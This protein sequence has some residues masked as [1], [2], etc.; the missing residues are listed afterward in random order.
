MSG[1]YIHIPF[2]ASFCLYCDFYSEQKKEEKDLYV[3]ALKREIALRKDFLVDSPTTLYFGGG[4]PS[5]MPL[6]SL[7]EILE[8]IKKYYPNGFEEVTIEVNPDDI[9]KEYLLGLKSLGFN[10]I[11]MGVQSFN[12]SHLRWMRRRHNAE[13]AKE[14]FFLM[15]ECGFTNISLDLIFGYSSLTIEDWNNDLKTITTLSPEH[16]SA[17][18]MTLE[19][20]SDLAKTNYSELSSDICA[21]QYS[22][23]QNSLCDSGYAQYEISNFSKGEKYTSKH[24]S[25]YWKREP[26]LGLGP[27]AHSFS[28]RGDCE[29]RS[30]NL[31]DL[32]LY[33]KA[34]NESKREL[35]SSEEE[36]STEEIVEEMVMLG[37][38]RSSGIE[39]TELPQG[40]LESNH[41][42]TALKRAIDRGLIIKEKDNIRIPFDKLFISD[43]IILELL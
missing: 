11:S 38:R 1:I 34:M 35:C 29:I 43:Y 37:L 41:F 40:Y 22:L 39:L 9:S 42:R 31:P 5:T 20:G 6:N 2:C 19:K 28:K 7:S 4:T 14:A 3:K 15:R 33:L 10:R 27:S 16:I 32:E 24:N 17:Y 36:L 12:D 23:L 13:Q 25:S 26:Y 8:E 18:Q 21:E 30:W